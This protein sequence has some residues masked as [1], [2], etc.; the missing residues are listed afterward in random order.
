MKLLAFAA[1]SSK[2]SINKQ[3]VT[4]AS[5]LVEGASVE[6]LDINDYEMPLFST[7][8]EEELG[9]PA[10]AKKFF[11]K[12]AQADALLI[13]LAEHNGNYTAAYKNLFDWTSRIDMKVYQHKPMTILATSP[14]PGGANTVLQSAITSAGFFAANVQSTLSIP[15][16]Y[17]NFDSEN[18]TITNP[19]IQAELIAVL[20]KL[21]EAFTQTA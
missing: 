19:A 11:E 20:A 8:R 6:I 13:S 4:Y 21:S 10:A 1:S 2:Q 15:N 18:G 3:L 7:D 17:A 14:G 16:F 5:S 9:Q 12:I